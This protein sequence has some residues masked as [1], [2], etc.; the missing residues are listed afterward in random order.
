MQ[1]ATL[2]VGAGLHPYLQACLR[3]WNDYGHDL[4]VYTYEPDVA[5]PDCVERR[6]ANEI[7]TS[8]LVFLYRPAVGFG[9]IAAFSNTFRY[10]MVRKTGM[11]WVDTDVLCV[12]ADWPQ[13]D[14]YFGWEDGP[15]RS[16]N[17]A[18][19]GAPSDSSLLAELRAYAD[20]LDV[21]HLEWGASGPRA[22]TRVIRKNHLENLVADRHEFY[23]VA[24]DELRLLFDPAERDEVVR[25]VEGAYTVHLW[26]E[27][28]RRCRVPTF[29]RPPAGS[30]LDEVLEQHKIE[31]PI[32]A[33]FTDLDSLSFEEP[34]ATV[35]QGDYLA[36][37]GWAHE[38][39]AA[40]QSRAEPPRP[41]RRFSRA[42]W[43]S[44]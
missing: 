35:P 11:I 43:R 16:C 20:S 5:L 41:P 6:D 34:G 8:D 19:F 27:M 28:L 39:E 42:W 18:I 32:A 13:R 21:A 24:H 38:L 22:L 4:V 12:R 31:I 17:T 1:F 33:R 44:L 14:Y 2:Y 10:E 3:S 30:W 15:R 37:E 26:D 29:L 23:P 40:L 9:S 25:R 7:L 36:L